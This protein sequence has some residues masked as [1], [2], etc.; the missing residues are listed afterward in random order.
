MDYNM[1]SDSNEGKFQSKTKRFLDKQGF[2]LILI[3]CLLILG[4]TAFATYRG[5]KREVPQAE[6]TTP[7]PTW[8]PTATPLPAMINQAQSMED[9]LKTPSASPSASTSPDAS[10]AAATPK[11]DKSS[12]PKD[13]AK[14]KAP[15]L[16]PMPV[17]GKVTQPYAG[18]TL[19]YSKTLDQWTSHL[20]IDIAG[21]EGAAVKSIAAG[22]VDRVENNPL[23]GYSITIKHNGD[24]ES[25]YA[26]LKDLPQLNVGDSVNAGDI[27]GKVG[28]SA[29]AERE[30]GPHVHFELFVGGKAVNPKGRLTGLE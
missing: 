17:E 26:N 24:V 16:Y 13:S 3:A 4:A 9:V 5:L 23:M 19:V 1:N 18:E 30:D 11:P 8:M 7:V 28:T 20:G 22:V 12:T 2:Y 25:L 6:A 21:E 27:I 10:G 29:I 14:K 15:S